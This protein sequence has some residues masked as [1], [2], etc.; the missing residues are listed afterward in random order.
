MLGEVAVQG[1]GYRQA[2]N[3]PE[4]RFHCCGPPRGNRG[5]NRPR[6]KR[7]RD[8]RVG[9]GAVRQHTVHTAI[10]AG[11]ACSTWGFLTL[12][13]PERSIVTEPCPGLDSKEPVV[14]G[15]APVAQWA[16]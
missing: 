9:E 4:I 6:I 14:P 7:G 3:D 11:A 13:S 5:R 10:V 1:A 15:Q 16:R 8:Q 12:I 2:G